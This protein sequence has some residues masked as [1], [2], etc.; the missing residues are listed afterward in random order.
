MIVALGAEIGSIL[1]AGRHLDFCP[2]GLK[3]ELGQDF[4]SIKRYGK[5][6]NEVKIIG[7]INVWKPFFHKSMVAILNFTRMI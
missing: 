3:I 2:N 4:A 6:G 1:E 5:F 7:I